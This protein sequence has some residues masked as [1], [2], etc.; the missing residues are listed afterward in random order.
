VLFNMN[1]QMGYLTPSFGHAAFYL[2]SVAPPEI[3]LNLI[4]ASLLPFVCL[5]AVGLSIVLFFPQAA[6]WL[7][8]VMC[9]GS[10]A[11]IPRVR[12]PLTTCYSLTHNFPH[13]SVV[14]GAAS[15]A[16]GR[17]RLH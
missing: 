10:P 11:T 6:L 14:L 16:G 12:L 4:L 9:Q 7:P 15:V 5:Q 3:S 1:M 2:K 13:T 8:S 17:A